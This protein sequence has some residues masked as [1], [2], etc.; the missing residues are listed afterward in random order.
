MARAVS[1][2]NTIADAADVVGH[3]IAQRSPLAPATA[4]ATT[5]AIVNG[6]DVPNDKTF[7]CPQTIHATCPRCPPSCGRALVGQP[8]DSAR[9]IIASRQGVLF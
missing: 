9:L 8:S 6:N 5:T 7:D 2:C 1:P 4:W 3:R